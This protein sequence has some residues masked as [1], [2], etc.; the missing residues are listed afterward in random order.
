MPSRLILLTS[1]YED[2]SRG[3]RPML[4]SIGQA[5]EKRAQSIGNVWKRARGIMSD[6]AEA[7]AAAWYLVRHFAGM[8][9][10]E[11]GDAAALPTQRRVQAVRA[12]FGKSTAISERN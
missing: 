10:A 12:T 4:G 2:Q 11:F 9:F 1:D 6:R 3:I 8:G 5:R 7:L